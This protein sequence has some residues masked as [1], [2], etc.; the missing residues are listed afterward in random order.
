MVQVYKID[1]K[2]FY[3]FET[4]CVEEPNELEIT[5]PCNTCE[6]NTFYK[7]KWT[8][9]MWVEGATQEEIDEINKID[10]CP[11]KTLEERLEEAEQRLTESEEEK[12]LL[13]AQVEANTSTQEFLESCLMEMA[14]VVYA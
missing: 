11:T 8:G 3:I 12:K 4:D 14:E 13:K 7:P 1:E 5:N 6:E 9:E 2:G 10:I